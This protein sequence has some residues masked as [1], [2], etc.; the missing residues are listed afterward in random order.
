MKTLEFYGH[1]FIK[2]GRVFIQIGPFCVRE[3]VTFF[4]NKFVGRNWSNA[5]EAA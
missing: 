3:N 2:V 4:N 1:C 5:S